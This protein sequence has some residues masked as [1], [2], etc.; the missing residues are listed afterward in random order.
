MESGRRGFRRVL[1]ALLTSSAQ[2]CLFY[3]SASN[4][5]L[6]LLYTGTADIE[7]SD[8]ISELLAETTTQHLVG[9]IADLHVSPYMLE[10]FAP[11]LSSRASC[12]C[13]SF[14]PPASRHHHGSTRCSP[15][16]QTCSRDA[17]GRYGR[18]KLVGR[19]ETRRDECIKN[20]ITYV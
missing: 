10:S 4:P 5:C 7:L 17:G 14:L 19:P 1:A 16:S 3:R 2:S 18:A 9:Y 13:S 20:D 8:P 12:S 15:R 11:S 6:A